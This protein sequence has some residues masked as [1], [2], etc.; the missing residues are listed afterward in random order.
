MILATFDTNV[1]VSS[2]LSHRDDAAT[3]VIVHAMLEGHITPLYNK[4]ILDEYKDVLHRSKFHFSEN[5]IQFLLNS[6]V[7][8]GI[9]TDRLATG[10]SFPDMDDLVFYEVTMS[11]ADEDA[12]LITGNQKHFPVQPNIV[13][14]AEMLV[15]LELES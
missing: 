10:L 13:T 4:E 7:K 12:Y 14:P 6:I 3:V 1:L 11:K 2:L 15:I 5:R 8:F 9:E